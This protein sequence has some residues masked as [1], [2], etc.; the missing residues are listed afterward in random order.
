MNIQK[1]ADADTTIR[2]MIS[3]VLSI[4][5]QI[6]RLVLNMEKRSDSAVVRMNR[7]M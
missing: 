7:F 1:T 6:G 4:R 5:I 3:S 2:V